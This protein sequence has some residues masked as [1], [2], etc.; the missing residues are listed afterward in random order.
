MQ[1][2]KEPK[3]EVEKV[4]IQGIIPVFNI[5]EYNTDF[6]IYCKKLKELT[7]LS[8]ADT[9]ISGADLFDQNE[10]TFKI[11]AYVQTN[12]KSANIPEYFK[13]GEIKM[14]TCTIRQNGTEPEEVFPYHIHCDEW[15]LTCR[16][17]F[18]T[19]EEAK[20]AL[21]QEYKKFVITGLFNA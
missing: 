14:D 9:G 20:F 12:M 13:F 19:V 10:M 6:K 8:W 4:M 2:Y 7:F 15:K 1:P 5:E 16:D 11:G 3:F 17:F 21:N 18:K